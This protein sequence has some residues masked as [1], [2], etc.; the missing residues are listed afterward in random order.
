MPPALAPTDITGVIVRRDRAFRSVI[1]QAGQPPR[2]RNARVDDRYAALVRSITFQLL[3]TNAAD[4]IHGR[5]RDLCD[6]RVTV[7]SVL[8]AGADH[9]RTAGLSRTKAQAMVDL[10]EDV[11][12]GRVQL[13]RHG[14]MSDGDV[15]ADVTAVRGIGPWTAQMDLMHTLA[16]PDV[17][18]AGDFGVRNGWTILH[19]LDEIIAESDLRTEGEKFAGVRSAVAWYC[20]QAVHFSRHAN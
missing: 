12:D 16:R 13:Q 2:W 6:G 10:A 1:A 20:W 15:V 7:E 17:W 19:G 5:V 18:P 8:T 14:R 3:A 9:L 11:R 4:T